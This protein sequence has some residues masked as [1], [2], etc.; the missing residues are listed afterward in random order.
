[1]SDGTVRQRK[2]P[3]LGRPLNFYVVTYIT[4]QTFILSQVEG[5]NV[6]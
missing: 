5:R 2:S 6:S 1:L 3:P 4:L